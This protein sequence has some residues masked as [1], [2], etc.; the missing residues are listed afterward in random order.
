MGQLNGYIHYMKVR[1]NKNLFKLTFK[2][3]VVTLML[4]YSCFDY[5]FEVLFSNNTVSILLWILTISKYFCFE[6][7][8]ECYPKIIRQSKFMKFFPR[9]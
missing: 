9:K 7:F 5:F 2:R 8:G 1:T 3:E 6:Y 4:E